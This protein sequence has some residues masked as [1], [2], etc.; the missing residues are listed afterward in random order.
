[1]E[2][3]T[4][5]WTVCPTAEAEPP[6]TDCWFC[7]RPF[8]ASEGRRRTKEHIFPQWILRELG[9]R[10]H[11][12]TLTWNAP[13]TRER[14]S[15]RNLVNDALV[16]GRVCSDCNNG[17]MSRLE[18]E[19][20]DDLLALVHGTKEPH[21]LDDGA[22]NALARWAA[23]T[24]FAAQAVVLGPKLIPHAHRLALCDGDLG[25]LQILGRVCPKD[26]GLGTSGSQDWRVSHPAYARDA[27]IDAVGR[28]YK[29]VV[30]I[31]RFI[32]AVCYWPEPTWPLI[33]SHKSHFALW[34]LDR[35]WA[36]YP[37]ATDRHNVP[38]TA[39]TEIIDIT[40]GTMICHPLHTPR[41][42]MTPPRTLGAHG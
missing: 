23:K 5:D 1:M 17:W 22:R 32:C 38:A 15:E 11:P 20:H 40:V 28:S 39:H 3:R 26:I 42:R 29:I 6:S 10:K 34:P 18:D 35:D 41:P 24:A 19:A 8:D 16:C 27:V 21:D 30:A 31:G 25:D 37:Y 33:V 2:A 12:F 36:Y 7:G 4:T 14:I 13:V 9:V